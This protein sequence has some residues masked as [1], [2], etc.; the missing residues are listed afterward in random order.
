LRPARPCSIL[1]VE[2]EPAVADLLVTLLRDEGYTVELARDGVAAIALLGPGEDT[3]T[4]YDLVLLDMMLPG[5]GG[6]AVLKHS[7]AV[8]AGLPIV[9]LSADPHALA[10][11]AALGSTATLSKPF[12]LAELLA[13][14]ARYASPPHSS[15]YVTD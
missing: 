5:V 15:E 12:D 4:H 10:Q 8:Q 1:V 14:V 13:V 2:D 6:G 9:G 7:L 3:G 11:A